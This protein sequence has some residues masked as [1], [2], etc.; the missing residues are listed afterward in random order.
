[1]NILYVG[2]IVQSENYLYYSGLSIAGNLMQCN[3]LSSIL[4][5]NDIII[6]IVSVPPIAAFPAD[7]KICVK[8]NTSDIKLGNK[9]CRVEEIGFF[10]IPYIKQLIQNRRVYKVC[11]RLINEK[12]IDAILT[13]NLYPQTGLAVSKI[14]MQKKIQGFVI[15]ADLPI[16]DNP[17]RNII[18]KYLIGFYNKLTRYAISKNTNFIILNVNASNF[19]PVD[20]KYIIVEGGVNP[21]DYP[22]DNNYD[23][24]GSNTQIIKKKQVIYTGSLTEYSG[25]LELIRAWDFLD[26]E[27]IELH[28]YGHGYLA[29]QIKEAS[30]NSHGRISYF[31][32]VERSQILKIQRKG[33]L[34][35]NP[36][37]S[38]GNI[39]DFTFPSKLLEYFASGIPIASTVFPGMPKEYIDNILVCPN[40]TAE[41]FAEII[42]NIS[43]SDYIKLY[44][45][46]QDERDYIINQKSWDKQAK[47]II[48]FISNNK[49]VNEDQTS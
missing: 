16:N 4:K 34:L 19:L 40:A 28:I 32:S 21:S 17:E 14:Q 10:N 2:Q 31:G 25:I 27:S 12:K 35:F 39:A 18:S 23:N 22:K 24:F 38:F 37:G 49:N 15:L 26:D 48:E 11:R 36:R 45:R 47:R 13:Y 8:K 7:K 33:W 42:N 6:D 30:K 3:I 1:M 5:E 20:S 43:D 41:G 46:A 9:L 44:E 29:E